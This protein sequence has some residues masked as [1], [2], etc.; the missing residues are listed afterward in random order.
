MFRFVTLDTTSRDAMVDVMFR[1]RS[2]KFPSGEPVKARLKSSAAPSVSPSPI[3]FVPTHTNFDPSL[4]APMLT[5]NNQQQQSSGSGR[6][7]RSKKGQSNKGKNNQQQ[8]QQ[9]N[10]K[11]QGNKANSGNQSKQNGKNDKATKKEEK[12]QE[13]PKMGEADFPSLPP[14]DENSNKKIEVEKVPDQRS[15]YGDDEF[16]KGHRASGFSDSSSTA[17]T[18]TASTP[19]PSQPF[20]VGGYAAALRKAAAPQPLVVKKLVAATATRSSS[21]GSK[22]GAMNSTIQTNTKLKE[23]NAKKQQ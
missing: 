15:D 2:Q 10:A 13:P 3:N 21:S 9:Q 14:M 5:V 12:R 17:T 6:K 20:V 18:S 4:F 1:L 23:H 19:N 8:Q 11:S 7:K 16:D 22:S